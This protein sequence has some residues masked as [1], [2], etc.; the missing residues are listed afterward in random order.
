M[1]NPQFECPHIFGLVERLSR[2]FPG[3]QVVPAYWS[4]AL[5]EPSFVRGPWLRGVGTRGFG[6]TLVVTVDGIAFWRPNAAEPLTTVVTSS[7]EDVNA[8]T[9]AAPI[10]GRV[11]PALQIDLVEPTERLMKYVQLFPTNE[12]GTEIRDPERVKQVAALILTN[13]GR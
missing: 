11:V 2:R 7:V 12:V 13:V 3:A 8:V 6:V 9:I 4:A 10:G 1:R 5:L